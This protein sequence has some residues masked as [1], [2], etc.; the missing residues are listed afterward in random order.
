MAILNVVRMFEPD[1]ESMTSMEELESCEKH[2]E[3][4]LNR[5]LDRKVCVLDQYMIIKMRDTHVIC[6][7]F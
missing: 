2:L 3:H 7:L 6:S 4:L 1:P 5:V